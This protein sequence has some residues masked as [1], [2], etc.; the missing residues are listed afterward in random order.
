MGYNPNNTVDK[1]IGVIVFLAVVAG[2]A[3]T[4]IAYF[5]NISGSGIALGAV[6]ATVLGLLFGVFVLKSGMGFLK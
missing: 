3:S 6:V 1:L 4:V 2:F 5:T